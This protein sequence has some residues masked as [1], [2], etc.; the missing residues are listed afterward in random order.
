MRKLIAAIAIGLGSFGAAQAQ[1]APVTPAPLP[2][3]VADGIAA[4]KKN[5]LASDLGFEIV[6]DLVTEVGPRPAG[7]EN[8]QRAR[9]WAVAK[10]KALGFTNVHV[11][12]FALPAWRRTSEHYEITA[13]YRQPIVAVALGWSAPTP[14][15]G[16]EA[17]IVRFP[18]LAALAAAPAGSLAGK[19]AFIDEKAAR[20]MDGS[21]YGQA[22]RKRRQGA[23]L[24]AEKGALASVIRTAGTNPDRVANTGL[25]SAVGGGLALTPIPTAAI[26][27]PDC[28]E[29][30]R[31]L[32]RGPVRLRLN[33]QVETR[34]DAQSGNVI[35][36]IR[37]KEAPNEIV[38]LGGHLDSWDITPGAN[39]DG[40]GVAMAIAAAKLV[41]T[42]KAKPRR[43]IRVVLF[44]AEEVGELGGAA[45]VKLHKDEIAQTIAGAESDSG[46]AVV[47]KLRTRFAD[48]AKAAAL[49]DLLSDMAIV[50][51]STPANGASEMSFVAA[52]GAPVVDLN[53]DTYRY[54]DV[55][56]T[57]V[58]TIEK[59]DPVAFR[60]QVAAYAIFAYFASETGWDFRAKP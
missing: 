1:T 36:E 17:E 15:D 45:Y 52:A 41:A 58:D 16:L 30:E 10:M 39:D 12:P 8:E 43:T 2:L 18:N 7:W 46:G 38:L 57:A 53:T 13:P 4:L 6:R 23:Q 9:D 55:H 31:L 5:A 35:G 42:Q 3:G 28:D 56:H 14:A 25:A 54:F 47:W 32:A 33:I 11:E 50:T 34:Q 27:N 48:P 37:G 44:G 59:V 26:S 24:A 22:Q 49:F 29:I 40:T 21:G 19:I 60:Q 51:D 20:T